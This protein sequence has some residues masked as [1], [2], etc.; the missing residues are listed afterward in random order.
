MNLYIRIQTRYDLN[1]FRI[2]SV[3]TKILISFIIQILNF[4]KIIFLDW[5]S[6]IN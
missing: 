6:V 5:R 1:M 3:L 4:L 2:G